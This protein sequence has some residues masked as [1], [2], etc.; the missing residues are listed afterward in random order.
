[1]SEQHAPPNHHADYPGFRGCRWAR[2]RVQHGLRTPR[3]C[4]ARRSTKS[5]GI[6]RQSPRRRV[7]TRSRGPLRGPTGCDRHW[8]R[9]SARHA[10]CSETSDPEF[11]EGAVRQRR[12]RGHPTSREF[13]FGG[14]VDRDGAPLVGHRRRSSRSAA[15]AHHWRPT[16]RHGT[17]SKTGCPRAREPRLDRRTSHRLRGSMSRR[18]F[19]RRS[20]GTGNN[21]S[22][23]INDQCGSQRVLMLWS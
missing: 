14:V 9:P 19:H 16:G 20:S 7:R 23:P 1:M 3:R 15:G 6:R 13:C 11:G 17:E 18:R 2:R 4:A 21:R 10:T 22:A 5:H 8:S 12:R